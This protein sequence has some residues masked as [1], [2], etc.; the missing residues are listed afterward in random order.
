MKRLPLRGRLALLTAVAV[1]IAVAACATASWFL[2]RDQL[3][4]QLDNQLRGRTGGMQLGPHPPGEPGKPRQ[5]VDQW[6]IL[7]LGACTQELQPLQSQ[8]YG[9]DD[10]YLQVLDPAG[11]YCTILNQ[12][13]IDVTAA[14]RRVEAGRQLFRNGEGT[15]VTGVRTELRVLVQQVRL[16]DG[17]QVTMMAGAP[18][19][20]VNGPLGGLVMVLL[21]VSALGVLGAAAAGMLTARAALRPVDEL[22]DA[23]EN[24]ARTED[25]TIKIPEVGTDEI[26]RLGRTFNTMTASLAASQERQ[27][28]L[29][30]DAGHELRT[31][32]TSMRTNIDLMIKSQQ[33]GRD[34]PEETKA[35]ML[36]SL[37]AQMHEMTSLI[38][39]LLQLGSPGAQ[40]HQDV[41]VGLHEVARRA[42]DRARLRGP[43]LVVEAELEPWYVQGDPDALERAVV[44]LCDNAVKFSPVGGT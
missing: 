7:A 43:G 33:T 32:L 29:I 1:A 8:D 19:E 14:D 3:Y 5:Q 20:S 4:E 37:K 23:V 2:V 11:E 16:G 35:K 12:G 42:V 30:A 40:H 6:V 31:P 10:R 41:E 17:R 24:I 26:A 27:Q 22:T 9:P 28:N 38:G 25:L 44:N 15:S 13:K 34:L 39:D 21:A 18:L 36:A